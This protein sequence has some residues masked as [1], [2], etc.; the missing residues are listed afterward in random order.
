MV[1]TVSSRSFRRKEHKCPSRSITP[2]AYR[3]LLDLSE[4]LD[5]AILSNN[6]N[7][8]ATYGVNRSFFERDCLADA[9]F[10]KNRRILIADV[11]QYLTGE[12]RDLMAAFVTDYYEFYAEEIHDSLY[13]IHKNNAYAAFDIFCSLNHFQTPLL[14]TAY[15]SSK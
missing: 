12:L 3:N 1:V 15:S 13:G 9:Y 14:I 8:L 6:E 5:D 11:K 4:Y 7:Y 2:D 10:D